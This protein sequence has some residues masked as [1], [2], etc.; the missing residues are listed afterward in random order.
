MVSHD[1]GTARGINYDSLV[2]VLVEAV[3]E[4][5]RGGQAE[6]VPSG[7]TG[8]LEGGD[9]GGYCPTHDRDHPTQEQRLDGTEIR[10]SLSICGL[11]S[12]FF[13]AHPY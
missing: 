10:I 11:W 6:V 9:A 4:Q 7:G 3:K 13:T 8:R 1:G 12:G 5:E 2:E